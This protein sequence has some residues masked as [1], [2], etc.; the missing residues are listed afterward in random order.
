MLYEVFKD[1][2][3]AAGPCIDTV[4]GS[5]AK[6]DINT[7]RAELSKHAD[8]DKLQKFGSEA[9]RKPWAPPREAQDGAGRHRRRQGGAGHRRQEGLKEEGR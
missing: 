9:S 2:L 4:A 5:L 8:A 7:A 1:A 6:G 3:K